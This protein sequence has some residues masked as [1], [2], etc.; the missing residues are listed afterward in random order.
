MDHRA[1]VQFLSAVVLVVVFAAGGLVGAAISRPGP[2]PSD[3]PVAVPESS[4]E[5][6]TDESTQDDR[7]VRMY[8]RAGAT[9][10]QA[11]II[12]SEIVPWYRE[13]WR[14]IGN[15]STVLA[16]EARRDSLSDEYRAVRR[17][18]REYEEPRQRALTD[19]ARAL[20]RALLDP[21]A[22]LAYDSILA[23]NDRRDRDDDGR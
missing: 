5:A 23:E 19:S 2:G 8:E 17:E 1:R 18:I 16:L 7:N 13:A 4:D 11:R 9:E 6:S 3:G 14:A 22:Q 15:D 21:Q 20:I 10:E 12:Q